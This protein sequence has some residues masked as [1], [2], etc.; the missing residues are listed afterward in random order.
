MP[1]RASPKSPTT[2]YCRGTTRSP[3]CVGFDGWNR[4]ARRR[5]PS[6]P[7]PATE[8]Y[9]TTTLLLLF[10]SRRFLARHFCAR[11]ASLGK[12]DRNRLLAALYFFPR[13]PTLQRSLFALVHC[14]FYFLRCLLA[15][16]SHRCHSIASKCC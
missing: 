8:P 1:G 10:T 16:L 2:H 6:P 3:N 14:F 12:P 4:Q 7:S 13:A 15:I 11:A 9:P 5:I